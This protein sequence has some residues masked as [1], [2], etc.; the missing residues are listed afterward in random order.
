MKR[1]GTAVAFLFSTSPGRGTFLCFR[2]EQ[3][4]LFLCFVGVGVSVVRR[5]DKIFF[6]HKRAR[7]MAGSFHMWGNSLAA[8]PPELPG[9]GWQ[10]ESGSVS[11]PRHPPEEN[12]LGEGVGGWGRGNRP[13]ALAEGVPPPPVFIAA[14]A[15]DVR[16]GCREGRGSVRLP[17]YRVGDGSGGRAGGR[18]GRQ[19][20]RP[21]PAADRAWQRW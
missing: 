21:C 4:M 1:R 2:E 12:A 18:R 14:K 7:H 9:D 20:S 11:A 19:Q 17:A 16:T 6:C 5:T 13:L 15:A 10:L 3:G 8:I